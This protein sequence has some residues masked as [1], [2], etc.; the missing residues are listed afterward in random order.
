MASRVWSVLP[1]S[2]STRRPV[3]SRP[4][5]GRASPARRLAGGRCRSAAPRSVARSADCRPPERTSG[6]ISSAICSAASGCF[7][8]SLIS[9]SRAP[10]RHLVWAKSGSTTW[11]TSAQTRLISASACWCSCRIHSSLASRKPR[12]KRHSSS[13]ITSRVRPA[14]RMTSPAVA[15][16]G[17]PAAPVVDEPGGRRADRLVGVVVDCGLDQPAGPDELVVVVGLVRPGGEPVG[18]ADP[19]LARGCRP[20]E[21]AGRDQ[22]VHEAAAVLGPFDQVP[23]EQPLQWPEGFRGLLASG[24]QG[25][26]VV[27]GERRGHQRGGNHAPVPARRRPAA[28]SPRG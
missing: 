13:S 28:R 2:S 27:D 23:S 7:I 18:R 21:R 10:T 11:R 20:V 9:P 25:E 4:G 26:Q 1:L 19:Q 6:S 5:P 15:G 14:S 24:V 3:R 8:E 16:E 12:E 17:Q 22:G